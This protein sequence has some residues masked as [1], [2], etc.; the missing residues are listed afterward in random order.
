[1]FAIDAYF[2]QKYYSKT[3]DGFICLRSHRMRTKVYFTTF[4]RWMF[5]AYFEA[6]ARP[7]FA[8]QKTATCKS[9]ENA[10]AIVSLTEP[11]KQPAIIVFWLFLDFFKRIRGGAVRNV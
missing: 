4:R 8:S 5:T 9:N 7:T 6:C 2:L 11:R 10:F 3:D 1:M